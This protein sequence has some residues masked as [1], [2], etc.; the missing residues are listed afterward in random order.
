MQ[1]YLVLEDGSVFVGE[2]FG[3]IGAVAGE[4]VFNTGMTGYQEV[5]TDASYYG[6]IVT[7]TYPLIG[8][9]GINPA[10]FE[11]R[12]PWIKGFIVKE[13]CDQPSHWQAVKS[14]SA[15]LAENGIPGLA[16]IDTRALTRH[17]R[18]AGT[19]RGVIATTAEAASPEQIAAWVAEAKAF[20]CH[21]HV[22]Q[23]TT[24]QPYRIFGG[25]HRVVVIDYGAKENIMRCLTDRDCDLVIAPATATFREILDMEPDGIMLTNGPGD[26]TD[27]PEGIETV[28]QLVELGTIPLFGICLG[29]QILSLAL[30]GKTFK[31]KYGHRGANHPVKDYI[32]GRVYITSQNHGYAVD[33]E[34]L[35]STQLAVTHRNLNDGTV[36]GFTHL[37]KPVFSVQYHPEASP[38]PEESRYLFDRFTALMDAAVPQKLLA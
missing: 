1:G 17:L 37:T 8:N 23:V 2:G 25:G 15:Y 3:A 13:L 33:E 26:P 5:L 32:T 35:D 36:E 22:K 20:E 9:Y 14:L 29:H 34:S 21:D 11:S 19:M 31:L 4:V 18:T 38:G 24:P 12:A 10:D 28:R 30:G 7:M 6:Q 16:G 27:L